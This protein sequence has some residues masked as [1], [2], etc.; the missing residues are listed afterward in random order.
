MNL[1]IPIE[2]R[3]RPYFWEHW[4]R[5]CLMLSLLLWFLKEFGVHLWVK[6]MGRGGGRREILGDSKK[7][8]HLAF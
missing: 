3:Y 5:S 1:F 4:R 8:V 6:E 7:V 2:S